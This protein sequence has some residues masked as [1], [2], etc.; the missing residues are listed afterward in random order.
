VSQA[1]NALE[2]MG[3]G[4]EESDDDYEEEN[5]GDDFEDTPWVPPSHDKAMEYRYVVLCKQE[6]GW[7]NTGQ[8]L[9]PRTIPTMWLEKP[10][11]HIE[12]GSD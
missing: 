10:L 3:A 11:Q 5:L 8:T 12:L 6:A 4:E 7:D 9:P 2:E 1:A